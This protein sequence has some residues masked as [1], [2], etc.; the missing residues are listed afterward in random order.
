MLI[1]VDIDT[2]MFGK[3]CKWTL[4]LVVSPS[5]STV[6]G[7]EPELELSDDPHSATRINVENAP[8]LG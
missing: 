8:V 6:D 7:G 4:I 2:Y 5:I 3:R 1:K